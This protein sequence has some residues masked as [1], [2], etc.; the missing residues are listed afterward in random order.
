MDGSGVCPHMVDA[1]HETVHQVEGREDDSGHSTSCSQQV[2]RLHWVSS[3]PDSAIR[4]GVVSH[5]AT[6]NRADGHRRSIRND[7]RSAKHGRRGGSNGSTHEMSVFTIRQR[8]GYSARPWPGSHPAIISLDQRRFQDG[9]NPIQRQRSLRARTHRSARERYFHQLP[10]SIFR[11]H[12]F[13]RSHTL[14][15]CHSLPTLRRRPP[16]PSTILSSL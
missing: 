15:K 5:I 6:R 12:L 13:R 4:G 9:T 2:E 8:V 10:S 7:R 3:L 11:Q 14:F 16:M 1:L